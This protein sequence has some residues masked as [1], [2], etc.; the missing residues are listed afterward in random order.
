MR[1]GDFTC[2]LLCPAPGRGHSA[3]LAVVCLSVRLSVPY[4]TSSRER[5]CLGSWNWQEGNLCHGWPVTLYWLQDERLNTCRAGGC[6]GAEQLVC[7]TGTLMSNGRLVYYDLPAERSAW[8]F[9]SPLAWGR[10]ILLRPR[11][12]SHSL[13]R[14]IFCK[15][16]RWPSCNFLCVVSP[17]RLT[18]RGKA[19]NSRSM[20]TVNIAP[21]L[22]C[23]RYDTAFHELLQ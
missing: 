2:V 21:M 22:H 14:W 23:P 20:L 8:L 10:R 1:H 7:F 5:K 11:Y 3:F 17:Y 4:L 6:H 16:D 13:L 18:N 12:R 15:T 19:P 9:K